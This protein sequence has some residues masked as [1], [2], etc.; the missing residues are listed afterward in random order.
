MSS[1]LLSSQVTPVTRTA[2]LLAATCRAP[3]LSSP[4]TTPSRPPWTDTERGWPTWACQD[5]PASSTAPP[6]LLTQVS[7]FKKLYLHKPHP[8]ERQS[9]WIETEHTSLFIILGN[10]NET[11]SAKGSISVK[12][13]MLNLCWVFKHKEFVC[14]AFHDERYGWSWSGELRRRFVCVF[15]AEASEVFEMKFEVKTVRYFSYFWGNF[16][17]LL[18]N[19]CKDTTGNS[20][21]FSVDIL[22]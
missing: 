18:E 11:E 15:V 14:E 7:P 10:K 22:S 2:C 6:T 12:V 9:A 4:T 19:N 5:P 16:L 1:S 17:S 3:R 20:L 21:Q 8:S 13:W